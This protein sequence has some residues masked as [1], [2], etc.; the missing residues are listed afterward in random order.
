MHRER[1]SEVN[2]EMTLPEDHALNPKRNQNV[3]CKENGIK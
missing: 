3:A 2:E 1:R